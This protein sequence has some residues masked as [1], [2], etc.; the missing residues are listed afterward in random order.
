M[1]KIP[2]KKSLVSAVL[3]LCVQSSWAS[4][5]SFYTLDSMG[6][7][8]ANT[9]SFVQSL[10]SVV[11][12][13]DQYNLAHVNANLIVS[14]ASAPSADYGSVI[15]IPH[16]LTMDGEYGAVHEKPLVD[17]LAVFAHEYGHLVFGQM[18]AKEIPSFANLK[19][20]GDRISALSLSLT[21]AN[22]TQDKKNQIQAQIKAEYDIIYKTPEMLQVAQVV[23]PYNELFADVIAVFNMQSKSAIYYALSYPNM[24]YGYEN[25]VMARDFGIMNDPDKWSQT[26]EHVLFSP[27]R[28]VIGSEDCWPRTLQEQKTQLNI[29][30]AL[31]LKDIKS[32]L[33]SNTKA[34]LAD[35]KTLISEYQ[36]SCRK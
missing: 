1:Q 18:L 32:K 4:V 8:T 16:Q 5:G 9:P 3:I 34:A 17:L 7:I 31:L 28:S 33:S 15:Y 11:A 22:L 6:K 26:E 36:K 10:T 14:G 27:L 13:I 29:L 30:A 23:S 20:V 25:Y 2:F 12:D 21:D 35:N 19:K 24:P